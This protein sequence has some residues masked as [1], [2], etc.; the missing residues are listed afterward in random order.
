MKLIKWQ[1]IYGSLCHTYFGRKRQ[2]RNDM[3]QIDKRLIQQLLDQALVNP[4]LRQSY[5][6]RNSE[7]DDSQRL[8]YALIP[9]TKVAIVNHQ[10][11]VMP[12]KT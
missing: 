3:I 7:D 11:N 10:F 8:L 4:R 9:G 2:I 1:T 6:L 12:C 5:D